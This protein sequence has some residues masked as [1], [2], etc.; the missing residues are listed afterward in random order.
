MYP[1][2]WLT[3][4]CCLRPEGPSMDTDL[5]LGRSGTR[6]WVLLE[7]SWGGGGEGRVMSGRPCP[8]SPTTDAHRWKALGHHSNTETDRLLDR[9][10]EW[11]GRRDRQR[12]QSKGKQTRGGDGIIEG[13]KESSVFMLPED[14]YTIY[15]SYAVREKTDCG[16]IGTSL[17]QCQTFYL[18]WTLRCQTDVTVNKSIQV[19]AHSMIT[20]INNQVHVENI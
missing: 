4:L 19:Y 1:G 2:C 16:E 3:S 10:T 8:W 11:S 13:E 18:Q 20:F 15:M 17:S 14:N 5:V 6:L 12:G 7:R 9:E